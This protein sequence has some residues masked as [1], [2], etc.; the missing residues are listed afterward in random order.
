MKHD[1]N[2]FLEIKNV[3]NSTDK[4]SLY[5]KSPECFTKLSETSMQ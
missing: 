1:L 5:N 2:Q 3:Q 4:Y